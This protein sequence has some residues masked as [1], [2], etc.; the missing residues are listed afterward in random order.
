MEASGA[1]L[2]G[3]NGGDAGDAGQ[4]QQVQTQQA[5]LAPSGME[6]GQL[7]PQGLDQNSIMQEL[8]GLGSG[9]GELRELLQGQQDGGDLA[10]TGGLDLGF[11]DPMSGLD[12]AQ[13]G[14]QLQ[15]LI[16][17]EAERIAGQQLSPL[18]QQMADLQRDREVE[19]FATEFPE[20]QEPEVGEAVVK[21]TA[22]YVQSAGWDPQLAGDPKMWKLVHLAR[23]AIEGH[24][25]EEAQGDALGATLEGVGGRPGGPAQGNPADQI[26]NG[27]T[28]S[29]LGS[30]VLDF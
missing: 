15:Q 7:A 1:G 16:A 30:S 28:D 24:Q 13:M 10:E 6:L 21:T 12:Q 4:G 17:Q 5:Q 3:G 23:R 19:M 9:L 18:Q 25:A 20:V 29:R 8:S 11:L 22:Q 26:V 14:Q 27:G 2:A